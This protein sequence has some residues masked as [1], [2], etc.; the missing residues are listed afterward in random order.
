MCSLVFVFLPVM[1]QMDLLLPWE[2]HR[3][4]PFAGHDV[5]NSHS[6]C[7]GQSKIT[8]EKVCDLAEAAEAAEADGKCWLFSNVEHVETKT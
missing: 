2:I 5:R 7:H 1:I 3:N 8:S 6:L 4:I